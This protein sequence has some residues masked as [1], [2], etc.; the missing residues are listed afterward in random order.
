MKKTIPFR[1]VSCLAMVCLL[2]QA[3][4]I[5]AFSQRVKE[6]K[7]LPAQKQGVT[8]PN[9]ES[10]TL[11]SDLFDQDFE[12]MIQLPV[13]YHPD[14]STVYPVMYV[15]DANRN[16]PMVANISFLLGFPR[17]DFPEVIV[18]GIGYKIKGL[19]EWAAWRTRDFTPTNVPLTD[20]NTQ[21]M[22]SRLS[23]R[24]IIVKSGGAEKFLGFIISELV[25]YIESNYHVSKTDKTLAGYSYGGL[26][27]M[28]AFLKHPE[29]FNRY[30]AGSPSIM[31]DKGLLFRFEEEYANSH[32]DLNAKLFISAGSLES[33][34][35]L[36]NIDKMKSQL[37]LRNYP[38]LFV[39]SYVFENE[40][41]TSC[42]PSAFMRAFVTLYK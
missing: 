19:E 5:N 28:Y 24:E 16:F 22:L 26:F 6:K 33:K 31:W 25:P 39:D 17:T 12:I 9:T 8:I 2:L 42:M 10:R 41:H 30:F 15:T 21:E 37:L 38:N 32:N 4:S 23:G 35:L 3:T 36:E 40:T 29:A 14:S 18:V 7:N 20:S 34:A 1:I 11:H 27:A 13:S